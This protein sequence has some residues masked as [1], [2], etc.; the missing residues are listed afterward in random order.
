MTD[1]SQDPEEATWDS[2][3]AGKHVSQDCMLSRNQPVQQEREFMFDPDE[4]DQT[5]P[6]IGNDSNAS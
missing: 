5:L 2:W 1:H 3:F 4:S 6:E